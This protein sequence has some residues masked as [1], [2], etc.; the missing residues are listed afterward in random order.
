MTRFQGTLPHGDGWIKAVRVLDT[1]V[2]RYSGPPVTARVGADGTYTLDLPVAGSYRVSVNTLRAVY[3]TI[4]ATATS[5]LTAGTL[6]F[7]APRLRAEPLSYTEATKTAVGYTGVIDVSAAPYQ[8]DNTGTV[9][10]TSAIQAALDAGKAQK[11]LVV[12]YGQFR[13]DGTLV[14]QT[15][16]DFSAASMTYYGTGTAIRVSTS[17]GVMPLSLTDSSLKA[18]KRCAF[19]PGRL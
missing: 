10:A 8:A 17:S 16:V 2:F 6:V 14:I 13:L 11:K 1:P 19:A 3:P 7:G 18:R 5:G 15:S 4:V 12:G 9:D